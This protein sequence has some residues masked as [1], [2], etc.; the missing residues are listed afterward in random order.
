MKWPVTLLSA[1]TAASVQ[2]GPL[3]SPLKWLSAQPRAAF[4]VQVLVSPLEIGFGVQLTV[5][6]ASGGSAAVAM[7][8]TATALKWA[9]T[10]R[11][12]VMSSSVHV[13]PL[14]SPL[15]SSKRQP[16]AAC[17]LQVALPPRGAL[18]AALSIR[19]PIG[20]RRGPFSDE[21]SLPLQQAVRGG[22]DVA[23]RVEVHVVQHLPQALDFRR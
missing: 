20:V 15:K 1:D 5:P 14:Q 12:A 22:G 11:G 23:V 17:A 3:Q 21:R 2:A 4:Q 7:V 16:S 18:R 8:W 9:T 13:G 19:E 10:L 6:P